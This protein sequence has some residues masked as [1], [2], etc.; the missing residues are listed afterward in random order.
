MLLM[1]DHLPV[2]L[3]HVA[4][5]LSNKTAKTFFHVAHDREEALKFAKQHGNSRMSL[6]YTL[7]ESFS[8]CK[9]CDM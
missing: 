8:N 5:K 2:L 4:D 1:I 6:S 3:N 7:A 9:L